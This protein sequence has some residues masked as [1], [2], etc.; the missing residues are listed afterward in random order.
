MLLSVGFFV[1][2]Y[3]AARGAAQCLVPLTFWQDMGKLIDVVNFSKQNTGDFPVGGVIMDDYVKLGRWFSV[4]HRR[5][6]LFV[7]EACAHLAL[8][9]SEYVMLI[10][11]FDHEGVRQDDLAAM[12]YLD[13]AV[14][15]RTINL[16]QKKDLIY[17]EPDAAD[18]R[19]RHIYLTE[20]GKE[21]H[22]YLRN[23][24]QCW[25]D[26]LIADMTQGEVDTMVAGFR[27]LV[28]RAISAKFASLIEQIP[29]DT[30]VKG[31]DHAIHTD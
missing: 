19:V 8:T 4:V 21:Q 29:E 23:I 27:T 30:L 22:I 12:L 28:E 6:Q 2:H 25:V 10:R 17:R 18:K 13:K 14:V 26:Y 3:N 5:S 31:E 7:T 20:H 11:I 16:L 24:I 15:T 1:F 9:Y